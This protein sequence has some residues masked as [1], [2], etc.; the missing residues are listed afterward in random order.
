MNNGFINRIRRLWTKLRLQPIRVFCFHQVSETFDASTMWECDW[1]EITQF[2][3]NIIHL[4][5]R[6][7][8]ISLQEAQIKL[9]HDRFRCKEYAVLTADDGWAS[10]KNIVPWL[11]ERKIPITLFVNPAYLDGE[12]YQERATEKL[13]TKQEL[14]K[15][16]EENGR[17]VSIASH[18]WNH[19][20]ATDLSNEQFKQSV[21]KSEL[22]LNNLS[23]KVPYFA[24]TYGKFTKDSMKVL[25]E[26]HLSPVLMDGKKNYKYDG[27]IHRECID[28]KKLYEE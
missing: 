10:L 13:L 15:W 17:Y 21:L 2:K 5:Q 9:E 28:A 14:D 3:K 16:S 23:T 7:K 26:N 19:V 12:H 11:A 1:T 27:Y 6:Y 4:S 8:F 20:K 22:A 24:Y 25:L 18:G